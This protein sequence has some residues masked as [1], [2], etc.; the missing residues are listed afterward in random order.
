MKA[1]ESCK[2]LQDAEDQTESSSLCPGGWLA[3]GRVISWLGCEQL[4]ASQRKL[5]HAAAG[6]RG[7]DGFQAARGSTRA[8]WKPSKHAASGRGAETQASSLYARR[9]A[10]GWAHF[11]ASSSLPVGGDLQGARVSS[12]LQEVVDARLFPLQAVGRVR[13]PVSKLRR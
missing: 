8:P 12:G 6:C 10:V 5:S 4:F 3:V 2:Q 9:L 11:A 1:R 7:A 13:F